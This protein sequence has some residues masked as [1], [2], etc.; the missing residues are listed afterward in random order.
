M[1]WNPQ[2]ALHF[3][4]HAGQKAIAETQAQPLS[5]NADGV[6]AVFGWKAER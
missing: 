1:V 3:S 2:P 4:G 5:C 6:I